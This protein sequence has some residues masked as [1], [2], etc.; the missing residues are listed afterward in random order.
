MLTRF[1]NLYR[2]VS[3]LLCFTA[4]PVYA[5]LSNITEYEIKAAFLFNLAGFITWPENH[6]DGDH[7][8]HLCVLGHD[9]F[10]LV[11]DTL[12]A[13]QSINGYPLA[14]HRLRKIQNSKSCHILF[15]ST[16]E[17]ARLA[18]TLAYLDKQA[19][20]TVSDIPD[21]SRRGGMIEFFVQHNKVRLAI[22]LD[23]LQASPLKA[24]AQ[25]LQV[26]EIVTNS[27]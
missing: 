23:N 8:F 6:F 24:S 12:I 15:I 13:G 4:M 2:R 25:L 14:I 27:P 26:S 10:G 7:A 1:L 16:S 11:L 20:L 9:P 21:F 17:K 22:N 5:A 18:N 3:L 19:V